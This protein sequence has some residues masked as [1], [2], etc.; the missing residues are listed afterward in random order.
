MK[1][2]S[3]FLTLVIALISV[4]AF[5]IPRQSSGENIAHAAAT[6]AT[7]SSRTEA[8]RELFGMVMRDPFYEYNTDPVNFHE[9][10]NRVALERQVAELAAAGVK[11][12]R[13]EFFADYK[14][15]KDSDFLHFYF[16][17]LL[18][19]ITLKVHP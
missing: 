16:P 7:T 9:A 17:N 8:D 10:T 14:C 13:M 12:V 15:Q 19:F 3:V 4:G 2:I 18:V 11:W 6:F 5:S 1:K